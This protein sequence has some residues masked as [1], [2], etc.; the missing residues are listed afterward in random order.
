MKIITTIAVISA[1]LFAPIAYAADL[2]KPD[3]FAAKV[4]YS[5]LAKA[6]VNEKLNGEANFG[7]SNITFVEKYV[8]QCGFVDANGSFFRY[9]TI[10]DREN[11]NMVTHFDNTYLK[12]NDLWVDCKP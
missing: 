7:K 4:G 12:F 8:I 3:M 9:A 5:V 1:M 11:G 10:I 2:T 6:Q